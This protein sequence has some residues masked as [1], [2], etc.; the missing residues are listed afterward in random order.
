M[1]VP[2]YLVERREVD[3]APK[4]ER[5]DSVP[6]RGKNGLLEG[7]KRESARVYIFFPLSLSSPDFDD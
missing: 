4:H 2:R 1:F 6:K 5:V 3:R 7:L